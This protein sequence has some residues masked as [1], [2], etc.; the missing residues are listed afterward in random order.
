MRLCPT[1]LLRARG[2]PGFMLRHVLEDALIL[3]VGLGLPFSFLS[4][5]KDDF[6]YSICAYMHTHVNKHK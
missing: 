1:L 6:V 4:S 3:I 2:L 5:K